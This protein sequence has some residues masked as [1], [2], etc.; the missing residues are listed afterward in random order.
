MY[1]GLLVFVFAQYLKLGCG[2]GLGALFKKQGLRGLK[3]ASGINGLQAVSL[4]TGRWLEFLSS[5]LSPVRFLLSSRIA[6]EVAP[7]MIK[8]HSMVQ[9]TRA[10]LSKVDML[11]PFSSNG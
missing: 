5:D 11:D 3:K 6:Q 8:Q 1:G 2:G 7:K 9:T 10:D 4:S